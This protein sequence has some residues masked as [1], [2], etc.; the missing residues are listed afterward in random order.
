MAAQATFIIGPQLAKDGCWKGGNLE[1]TQP[2]R[3]DSVFQPLVSEYRYFLP[4]PSTGPGLEALPPEFIKLYELDA[5]STAEN[6]PY[7]AVASSLAKSLNS[8]CNLSIF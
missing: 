2:S 3:A 5:T 8:D 7:H 1:I 4:T 6:N